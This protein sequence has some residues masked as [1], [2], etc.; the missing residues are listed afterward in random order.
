MTVVDPL[1]LDIQLKEAW[2]GFPTLLAR[3]VGMIASPTAVQAAG[4]N[5]AAPAA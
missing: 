3:E 1:T 5:F 2:T 4:P